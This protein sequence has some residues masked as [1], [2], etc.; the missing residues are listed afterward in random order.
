MNELDV[1]VTVLRDCSPQIAAFG[2]ER[3]LTLSAPEGCS[4]AGCSQALS[5]ADLFFAL[6]RESFAAELNAEP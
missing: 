6:C 1:A 5:K 2:A 3:A 4:W